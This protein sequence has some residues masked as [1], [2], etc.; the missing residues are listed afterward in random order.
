MHPPGSTRL[1]EHQPGVCRELLGAGG[2]VSPAVGAEDCGRAQLKERDPLE[3]VRFR[4]AIRTRRDVCQHSSFRVPV[5]PFSPTRNESCRSPIPTR[6][7]GGS[8]GSRLGHGRSSAK[9]SATS[10]QSRHACF[11]PTWATGLRMGVAGARPKRSRLGGGMP[12]WCSERRPIWGGGRG[13]SRLGSHVGNPHAPSGKV[14]MLT[15]G[16]CLRG[17]ASVRRGRSFRT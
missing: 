7:R 3:H 1:I 4:W 10:N 11:L 6:P 14:R 17:G 13:G 16:P 9:A 8:R 2:F 5:L 15:A 12:G